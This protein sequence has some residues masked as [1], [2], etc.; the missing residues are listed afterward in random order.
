[1]NPVHHPWRALAALTLLGAL[2]GALWGALTD[3]DR[4][5]LDHLTNDEDQ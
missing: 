1:V 3:L 4:V 2:A 5:T